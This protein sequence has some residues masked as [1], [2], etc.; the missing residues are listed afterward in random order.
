MLV[1]MFCGQAFPWSASLR[2]TA[3]EDVLVVAFPAG[4]RPEYSVRRTGAR[5]ISAV[6]A[7]EG[8]PAP[9]TLTRQLFGGLVERVLSVDDGL[10]I[11]LRKNTFSLVT[12]PGKVPGE[13]EIHIFAD[14]VGARWDMLPEKMRGWQ[15]AIMTALPQPLAAQQARGSQPATR[16][17]PPTAPAE[18]KTE[19]PQPATPQP[20]RLEAAES[21]APQAKPAETEPMVATRQSLPTAPAEAKT[22]APQPAAPQPARMET[23]ESPAPQEI[24][25][26]TEPMAAARQSIP[27]APTVPAGQRELAGR[28]TLAAP[29]ET[30]I[31]EASAGKPPEPVATALPERPLTDERL[32][33]SANPDDLSATVEAAMAAGDN[34]TLTTS[35]GAPEPAGGGERLTLR[36]AL[37]KALLENPRLQASQSRTL[38]AEASEQSARGALLPHAQLNGAITRI[39]NPNNK[40]ETDSDYVNQVGRTWNLQLSQNI[41]DGLMRLSNYSRSKLVSAKAKEEKRKSELDTIEAVQREYFKLIRVRSDIKTLRSSVGR[42]ANQREAAYAFYKVEMAPRLVLLQVETALALTRQRLSKALNDEQVQMVKLNT[43]LGQQGRPSYDFSG[44]LTAYEYDFKLGFDECLK[45]AQQSLPELVIAKTDADIAQEELNV[46]EGKAYPRLDAT[47]SYIKQNTDYSRSTSTDTDRQYY[48]VGLNMSWEIFS[49]GEQYYEIQARKKLLQATQQELGNIMLTVRSMVRENYLN[50]VEAKNQI[51]IAF[52]RTREA[53]EAYRQ[54]S[55]RF[56]SGIGTNIEVL[57]AHEKVTAAESSLNQAQADFLISLSTLH[58]VM[59]KKDL[60]LGLLPGE[61]AHPS[62]AD[63][64][65]KSSSE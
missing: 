21:P 17:S 49:S 36:Q 4:S 48:T 44:D 46:T 42:L 31:A 45:K 14:P 38:G 10:V 33:S 43:L 24:Q 65:K 9:G 29:R 56:R 18:A 28:N 20:A 15:G 34:A 19:A 60:D 26:E 63:E 32:Y 52:L 61:R 3:D 30:V 53:E 41:F 1:S 23:A 54:A 11:Q 47:A 6:L 25:A 16:Q 58:R 5:E 40:S 62:T 13:L 27:P 64:E 7:Q 55:M 59:G 35:P 51:R 37:D 57:D 8:R 2:A 12:M 22:E 39:A 50:T